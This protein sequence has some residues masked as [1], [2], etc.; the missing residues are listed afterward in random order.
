MRI[1]PAE[2]V[3]AYQVFI[4]SAD[5]ANRLRR[6]V[7]GLVDEVFNPQL[8]QHKRSMRLDAV[9]W[10]RA[11]ARRADPEGVNAEFVRLARNSHLAMVLIVD[12]WGKGTREEL[13]AALSEADVEVSVLRFTR[14]GREEAEQDEI[15]QY[16]SRNR[17]HIR[18]FFDGTSPNADEAWFELTKTLLAL[19]LTKLDEH[20]SGEP[21]YERR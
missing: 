21:Y 9:M 16:L 12:K 20:P 1:R 11:A 6:R 15:G 2:Q 14:Q 7:K 17:A 13:E 8:Q 3:G 10:E 5:D 18:Y 19:V 4:S